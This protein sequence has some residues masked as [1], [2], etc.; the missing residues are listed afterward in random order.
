MLFATRRRSFRFRLLALLMLVASAASS[1]QSSRTSFSFHPPSL[2]PARGHVAEE[3]PKST[4]SSAT[5]SGPAEAP[6]AATVSTPVR[7]VRPRGRA[8][9]APKVAIAPVEATP[10]TIASA[11]AVRRRGP[12]ARPHATAEVGLG[13]TVL[14]VLGLVLLPVALVG[15]LLSGGGLV[16]GILTGLAALA[17]LVAWLDPFGR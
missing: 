10:A 16:W 15:L 7:R 13:T 2:S 9:Q 6:Q 1:C 17:V 3:P 5:A 4:D 11:P 12:L 8:P 14:G